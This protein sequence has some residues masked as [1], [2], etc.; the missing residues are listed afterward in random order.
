MDGPAAEGARSARTPS[1]HQKVIRRSGGETSTGGSSA[2]GGSTGDGGTTA[3][4]RRPL[5]QL[6]LPR[7]ALARSSGG[8]GAIRGVSGTTRHA[9]PRDRGK[10]AHEP[11]Q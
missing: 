9:R 6:M 1:T 7:T 5:G 4:H 3:V 10:K 11:A 2:A 8:L